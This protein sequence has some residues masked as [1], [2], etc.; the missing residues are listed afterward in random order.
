MHAARWSPF[1]SVESDPS[2]HY[3]KTSSF[4]SLEGIFVCFDRRLNTVFLWCTVQIIRLSPTEE[5]KT[6]ALFHD[7]GVTQCQATNTKNNPLQRATKK[8]WR[9]R[10]V[11]SSWSQSSTA[12]R[13]RR[14][15]TTEEEEVGADVCNSFAHLARCSGRR[16]R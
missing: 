15:M 11:S 3:R 10:P 13:S 9:R 4:I 5:T 16:R 1:T 14:G 2:H 12:T 6:S 7:I 8:W